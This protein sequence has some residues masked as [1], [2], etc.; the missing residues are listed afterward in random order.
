MIKL[1]KNKY[2]VFGMCMLLSTLIAFI[3]IPKQNKNK[4][5]IAVVK[6]NKMILANT[7]ITEDMLANAVVN[8]ETISDK[9]ITDKT[10]IIGKYT[11]TNIYTDDFI[12]TEKLSSFIPNS[13]FY[14]IDG[15]NSYA[16]SIT[17][18]SLSNGVSGKIIAGDIVSIYGFNTERKEVVEYNY[19]KYIE[20]LSISDTKGNDVGSDSENDDK[21][22]A[23]VT[24]K[25]NENQIKELILMENTGN[26]HIAFAGRGETAQNLLQ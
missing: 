19:L 18:K 6:V 24:L 26:I 17:L 8:S 7:L 4:G 2:F 25:V 12:T 3:I 11:T 14:K 21:T 9:V 1:I 22:P 20:V 16:V 5:D 13:N 15:K 23:T 10:K